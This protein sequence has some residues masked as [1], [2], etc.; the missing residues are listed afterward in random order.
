MPNWCE[1]SLSITFPDEETYSKLMKAWEIAK[2]ADKGFFHAVFTE[3]EKKDIEHDGVMPDW[4]VW[5]NQCWGTKWDVGDDFEL[6]GEDLTYSAYFN[7]AWG[8]PLGVY[9]KLVDEWNCEVEGYYSEPGCD[10]CGIWDN[11]HEESCDSI[12]EFYKAFTNKTGEYTHHLWEDVYQSV[13]WL[14]EN[15]SDEESE[16]EE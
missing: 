6:N 7:T 3:P 4:W 13:E 5:R 10:F 11:G 1:N 8:P 12:K 9:K 2:A 14:Y 15:D 16:T